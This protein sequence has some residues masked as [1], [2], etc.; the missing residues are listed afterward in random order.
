[1][2]IPTPEEITKATQLEKYVDA[3]MFQ[4]AE[5]GSEISVHLLW[6]TPA[7]LSAIAAA[8][9]MYE[10]KPVYDLR[11]V[12]PDEAE[13][14]FGEVQKTH[15]TAPLEFVKLHF[16]IEGVDRAFTHQMVRQRTAV[17][18]QESL[19]F[20]V[21]DHF[22]AE[23]A[24]PPSIAAHAPNS[25]LRQQ[26]DEHMNSV[27]DFY[28]YLVANDIP[29]ED[30]RAILPHNT[31]TRL[32]YCTDL[33]ALSEHSGNRLCTQAQFVWREVFSK[34]IN[35]IKD[36]RFDSSVLNRDE[37]QF[38]TLA[39]SKLFRP[40]CYSHGR[41][42]FKADFDRGCTIRERVDA[43]KFDEIDDNEWMLDEKAAWQ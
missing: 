43:G 10:G 27:G 37:W 13:H 41:C 23:A 8:C 33:R 22:A 4:A 32:H 40:V 39:E 14:Y 36:F 30:A 17:Y 20:A 38:I 16:M 11:N 34:I 35:A 12:T 31:T 26:W 1:M 42:P 21:K 29:A 6:M 18:A 2:G 24:V 28:N 3:S 9:Q 7:P 5:M 25:P 15:L 19:R